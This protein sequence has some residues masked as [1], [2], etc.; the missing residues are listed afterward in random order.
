MNPSFTEMLGLH[1]FI[2][3]LRFHTFIE[4]LGLHTF[5]AI[6]RNIHE[7][8]FNYTGL[9]ILTLQTLFWF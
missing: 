5:I 6:Y 3:M 2:E 1:T 8:S 7:S 4:M 9:Q